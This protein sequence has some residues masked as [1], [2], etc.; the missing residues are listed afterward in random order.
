[1]SCRQQVLD[2]GNMRKEPRSGAPDVVRN[3]QDDEQETSDDDENLL[4]RMEQVVSCAAL[5]I[6]YDRYRD[7]GM[8]KI[9]RNFISRQ[10][11]RYE[12]APGQYAPYRATTDRHGSPLV[13]AAHNSPN[14]ICKGER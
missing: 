3:D 7:D 10:K 9:A 4:R 5:D 12:N 2:V 11:R 14:P 6:R 8:L 1:M 13:V